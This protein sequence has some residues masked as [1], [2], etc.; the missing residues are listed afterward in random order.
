[1]RLTGG[2]RSEDREI[3]LWEIFKEK[4]ATLAKSRRAEKIW[5]VGSRRT[6]GRDPRVLEDR[7]S[8][9]SRCRV[10]RIPKERKP[11]QIWFVQAKGT[12]VTRSCTPEHKHFRGIE[13]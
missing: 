8:E 9:E 3:E 12:G 11:K 13:E 6:R 7:Y 4:S 10:G 2:E 5:T 1:V